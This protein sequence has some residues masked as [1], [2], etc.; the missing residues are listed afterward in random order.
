MQ[1]RPAAGLILGAYVEDKEVLELKALGGEW[2]GTAEDDEDVVEHDG[3]GV[4]ENGVPELADYLGRE[5][6]TE[7][8]H[9]GEDQGQVSLLPEA[10]GFISLRFLIEI[11]LRTR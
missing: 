2:E 6:H 8:T 7:L 10:S 5:E 3:V 4:G 11:V 9:F 1:G